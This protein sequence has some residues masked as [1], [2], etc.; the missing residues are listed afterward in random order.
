MNPKKKEIKENIINDHIK[1]ARN[2]Y[3]KNRMLKVFRHLVKIF[4]HTRLP[5]VLQPNI[6]SASLVKSCEVGGVKV[7]CS[8]LF[9][10]VPTDSGLCC[11]L[12]SNFTL[13]EDLEYSKLVKEMQGE[14]L[15][16]AAA[17]SAAKFKVLA[18]VGKE[19]GVKLMLD[20]HTEYEALGSVPDFFKAFQ[21]F[22]GEPDEYPVLN[23]RSLMVKPGHETNIDLTATVLTASPDIA[24]IRP[25]DRKC[26]F[27][28][29]GTTAGLKLYKTYSHKSC[30]F[31]CQIM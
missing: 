17:E 29:E 31:E 20:L 12:N 23:Q 4:W 11:A 24:G 25:K 21:V 16:E 19:K 14:D 30:V 10:K 1:I 6:S 26:F 22:V 18:G 9:T 7:N 15:K 5:C 3:T 28:N 8:A 13:N 2:Y 27:S